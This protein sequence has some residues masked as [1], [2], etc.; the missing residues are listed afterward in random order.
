MINN[1]KAENYKSCVS[2]LLKCVSYCTNEV[3]CRRILL[4]DYFGEKFASQSCNFTCD[5]CIAIRDLGGYASGVISINFI[6]QAQ[7]IISVIKEIVKK[8]NGL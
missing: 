4:L 7:V 8:G 1:N 2:N 5:N 3:D 6:G